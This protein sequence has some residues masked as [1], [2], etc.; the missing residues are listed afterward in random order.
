MSQ[1]DYNQFSLLDL[2]HK[3]AESQSAVLTQGLLALERDPTEAVLLEE[4]MRAAHSLKG[5]ARIVGLHAAVQVAHAM[6]DCFVAAQKGAIV[7][8]AGAVDVLLRSVDLFSR[9]AQTPEAEIGVWKNENAPEIEQ[10]V[11][12][13]TAIT[14]GNAPK[15]PEFPQPS[16]PPE[17][18]AKPEEMKSAGAPAAAK[19]DDRVLRVAATNLNR[20]LGLA[21]EALVESRWLSPYAESLL[22]LKR[23]Q[24]KLSQTMEA[25]RESLGG[26]SL[27]E[28]TS[29]LLT[30]AQQQA[31][32][33]V[34]NLGARHEELELY[35]RRSASLSHR[36]YREVLA[37]RMRPFADGVQGFQRLARDLA[38]QLGK[39]VKLQIS[40]ETTPVDR[41]VLERLEAPLGH[42]LRNALDHGLEAPEERL[43]AGKP[44]EGML[45]LEARHVAGLLMVSI[46]DDGRGVLLEALRAAVVSKKLTTADVAR[47]LSEEELLDFLFLPGFSMREEVTEISG[48]GVGLD[49]VQNTVKALGGS[50]RLTTQPGN[51]TRFQLQLPLTL[52]V[53]RFLLVE[54]AGEPYAIPLA[55]LTR[56]LHVARTDIETLEGREHAP[57]EGQRVGLVS[58]AQ[59]F[60]KNQ[61]S[62]ADQVS[63]VI[64]GDRAKRFGVVV[65]RFLGERQL[66]VQPLDPRLGKIKD[67][68]AGALMPDGSPVLILD[69]DDVMRSVELLI[70]HGQLDRVQRAGAVHAD[71]R[72]KRVLVVD[73][74]LTVRE[75]ERKLISNAGYEVEVS[76]D[77]MDGWN[78]VRTQPFDLVVTDIDMPRLDGI[79]LVRLIKN[80][81][82]LK[83]LPVMIVSYKDRPEDRNRGLEAGADYYLTKGSFHDETLLNAVTDLI[84][85]A[86]E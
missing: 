31:A 12:A 29:A 33:C 3:E 70:S 18:A 73:D 43:R 30:N 78:A 47:T 28:K 49:V 55:R 24:T 85:E 21:G 61:T 32:A 16:P 45:R 64:L 81:P 51:G 20:L 72:R 15:Q 63:V 60:G 76:I 35:T 8:H 75:L 48:R 57:F 52:S 69:V 5:A 34:Q 11:C 7:L 22:R 9:I 83:E 62:S 79:E 58:A 6:E 13:V 53:M 26:K 54:V 68:N 2:F 40:G 38:R 25:L 84:G 4:L 39:E 74:S 67:I 44:R 19:S 71:R 65:D 46:E 66:V 23:Q 77:G 80:D 86:L 59:I 36:L 10:M 27:D 82:R 17:S 37:S 56:T 1:N 14:S 42:L 50:V 41:D